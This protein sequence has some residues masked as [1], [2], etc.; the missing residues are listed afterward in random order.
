MGNET[1]THQVILSTDYQTIRLE[2]KAESRAVFAEG[3]ISAAKFLVG[4]PA[5]LYDMQSMVNLTV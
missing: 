2:H 5:G 3:A 1:G 4:K